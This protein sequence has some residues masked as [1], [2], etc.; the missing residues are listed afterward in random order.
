VLLDRLTH[1]NG[2]PRTCLLS[3]HLLSEHV[4]KHVDLLSARG[5][6]GVGVFSKHVHLHAGSAFWSCSASMSHVLRLLSFNYVEVT[7]Y[8][9][10]RVFL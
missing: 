3:L 6:G 5:L 2:L 9:R 4:F 7:A 1:A 8:S 10:C